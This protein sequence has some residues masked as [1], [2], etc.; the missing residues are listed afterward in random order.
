M[1]PTWS[2]AKIA[3][4]IAKRTNRIN[5][6]LNTLKNNPMKG[7]QDVAVHGGP[8]SVGLVNID[9]TVTHLNPQQLVQFLESW[10]VR[11][12]TNIRLVSCETAQVPHGFAQQFARLWGGD[13]V[14]PTTK[15]NGLLQPTGYGG[16]WRLVS[17]DK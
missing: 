3:E 11:R 16:K 1:Q 12:G 17:Y 7:Y 13:V 14:A 9:G 6:T 2:E 4:T 8:H 5:A 15:V 10:G